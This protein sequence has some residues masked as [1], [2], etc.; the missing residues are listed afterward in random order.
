M[1]LKYKTAQKEYTTVVS[2]EY[3]LH[4]PLLAM[5]R[6]RNT[7]IVNC[8]SSYKSNLVHTLLHLVSFNIALANFSR[9]LD[10]KYGVHVGLM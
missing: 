6:L 5:Q 3:C 7:A 9:C 1:S 8:S 10:Q 4:C 2:M